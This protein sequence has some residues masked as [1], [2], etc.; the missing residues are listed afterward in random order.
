VGGTQRDL[1]TSSHGSEVGPHHLRL[2]LQGLVCLYLSYYFLGKKYADFL[3][4]LLCD[5]GVWVM[6]HDIFQAHVRRDTGA[7]IGNN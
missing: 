3:F 7:G 1:H 4:D 6:C 5:Y 2:L